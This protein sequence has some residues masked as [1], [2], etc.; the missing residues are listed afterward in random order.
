VDVSLIE[1]GQAASGNSVRV[2]ALDDDESD[3]VAVHPG[4]A[5]L[6]HDYRLRADLT[7][8]LSLPRNLT[9]S[10]AQRLAEFIKILP[11]E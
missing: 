5:L 1:V 6:P 10:E 4:L 3:T 2:S 8:R 9:G 7:I 11:F